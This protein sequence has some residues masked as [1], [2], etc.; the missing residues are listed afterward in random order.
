[1]IY[2]LNNLN[3]NFMKKLLFTCFI[4]LAASVMTSAQ[5]PYVL[6]NFE[7]GHVNFTT[8]VNVNPATNMDTAVVANPASSTVNST[9]KCWRWKRLDAGTGNNQPWAGF[10]STLTTPIAAGCQTITLKYYRTNANSTLKL[11]L[12]SSGSIE[13]L[14]KTAPTKVNQWEDLTFDVAANWTKSVTIF[15]FQPDYPVDGTTIDIGAMMYIDEIMVTP[16]TPP[17]PPTSLTLFDDSSNTPAD[18][19]Y[20]DGSYVNATAPSTVLQPAAHQ[21]KLPVVTTPVKS[22][23]NALELSWKSVSGGDWVAMVAANAFAVF[24]V[25]SMVNLNFWINSPAIILKTAMPSLHMEAAA[26]SP[27]ETGNVNISN[28]MTTDLAANTWTKIIIPL[29]AIWAANPLFTAKDQIHGVFFT[30]NAIDNVQHILYLDNFVFDKGATGLFSPK[31]YNEINAYYSN[32]EI[33]IPNYVGNVSVFDITGKTVVTGLVS[34]G[35]LKVSVRQGIY[36]LKT[37]DGT[38]KIAVY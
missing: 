14:P 7:N 13:F 6:D 37:A 8:L 10:F 22:G 20:H 31:V 21:G 24:D 32:G 3:T 25:S 27:N 18:L 4:A 1:M 34:D 23:T 12:E 28:Y 29:A 15:G 35:K 36:I 38:A 16:G 5:T 9:A 19:T 11:H 33:R 2:N 17:P 30:Q 26:G